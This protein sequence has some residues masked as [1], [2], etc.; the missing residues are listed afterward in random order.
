MIKQLLISLVLILCSLGQI[1]YAISNDRLQIAVSI[2]P[3]KYFVEQIVKDT[4]DV[5]VMVGASDNPATFEPRPSQMAQ[6]AKTDIYFTIGVPFEQAWIKRLSLI[7]PQMRIVHL[8]EQVGDDGHAHAHA[9]DPHIWTNPE[10]V[11]NIAS[12]IAESL[13]ELLS[14][15]QV[16]FQSN[17]QSFIK[18]LSDID[19]YIKQKTGS[20]RK[21]TLIVT[22]P[23]WG[24]FAKQYNFTQ[25][26]IEQNG[27]T[28]KAA[29]LSWLIKL[30]HKEQIRAVFAQPQF[31]HKSATVLAKEIN[32]Q[33][34]MLNPLAYDYIDNMKQSADI[35]SEALADE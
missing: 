5:L 8:G 13:S 23:S 32:G 15:Y 9:S 20:L 27:K 3:Q 21:R 25:V 18:E 10:Q 33:V 26:S 34:Y 7:N 31:N 14:E 30:A 22:H 17:L 4:A 16:I 29:S 12:K 1:A 19:L 11:K 6:I 24:D 2:Q 35:I 28:I